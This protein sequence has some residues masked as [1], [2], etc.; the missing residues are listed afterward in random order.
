ML[1]RQVAASEYCAATQGIAAPPQK[2]DMSLLM[3]LRM[4]LR[5]RYI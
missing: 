4:P 3:T 1:Q 2:H 5:Q